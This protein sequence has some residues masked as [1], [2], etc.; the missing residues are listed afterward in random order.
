MSEPPSAPVT[1][2]AIS[3]MRTNSS[4]VSIVRLYDSTTS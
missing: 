2:I 4:S 3:S 1:P